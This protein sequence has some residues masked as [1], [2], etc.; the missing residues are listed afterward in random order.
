MDQGLQLTDWQVNGD[1]GNVIL[2]N[3][4]QQ[5]NIT[6]VVIRSRKAKGFIAG[7]DVKQFCKINDANDAVQLVRHG[8]YVFNKLAELTMYTIAV[9]EGFCM[10]GGLELAL[11]CR[12]RIALDD[13]SVRLGVPEVKLGIHSGW[14]GTV[15]LPQLIG[16]LATC[17][18]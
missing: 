6:A 17:E 16:P 18:I 12:Y 13:P 14:G 1:N 11:A 3:I 8:Q 9:I 5:K 4:I 10:G 15:R 7:A 2:D